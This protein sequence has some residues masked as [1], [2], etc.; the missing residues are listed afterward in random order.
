MNNWKHFVAALSLLIACGSHAQA[1]TPRIS[2][3]WVKATL[4]GASVSAAYMQIQS[5][6]AVKLV[7][8]ESPAAGLVE[9]HNMNMK[10]GVMEM[11]AMDAV[12]VP[13]GKQVTLKPGGMHVMMMKVNQPIKAGDK[14]PLILTFEGAD[15]KPLVVKLDA[16]AR[17]AIPASHH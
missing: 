7:K 16:T 12:D 11:K 1:D 3:V 15:K 17:E 13:A 5:E 9:L 10:D 6:R 2:D 8:V 14:V 4:P